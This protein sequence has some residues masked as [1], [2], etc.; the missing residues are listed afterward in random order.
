AG[1]DRPAGGG[2]ADRPG[3]GSAACRQRV[4]EAQ[5]GRVARAGVAQGDGE[6][7]LVASVNRRRIGDLE[8]VDGRAV[9]VD[10][11]G[12]AVLAVIGRGDR[13]GVVDLA[14]VRLGR[15]RDDVDRGR[16]TGGQ[17]GRAVDEVAGA[18]RP[19]GGGRADRP[20]QGA[21]AGRQ[22]VGELEA[23][24]VARAVVAQGDGEADLVA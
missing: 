20:G 4:T 22:R 12:R 6:A 19:A 16:G 13:G 10:E 7:D 2:R 11:V 14:A 5:T 21:A 1:H 24:H 18:D 23:G 8:D 15:C 3:Q 17:R 9:D